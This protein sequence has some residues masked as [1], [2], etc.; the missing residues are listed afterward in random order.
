MEAIVLEKVD[1]IK[2]AFVVAQAI[3]TSRL[4]PKVLDILINTKATVSIAC[5]GG[6]DSLSL[7]LLLFGHFSKTGRRLYV[8]H[9][10]HKLRNAESDAEEAFVREVCRQLDL[11]IIAHHDENPD[12]GASESVLRKKRHDFF[13]TCLKQ[14]NSN[15]LCFGH[16]RED[17]AETLLMRI[18]RG[19]GL[20]GLCGPRPV[21]DFKE[22]NITYLR[23]LIEIS[24][25][26][27]MSALE[28]AGVAWCED[29]SNVL[30]HYF[31]NRVRH[32][33][34][35]EWEAAA[36]WSI[37]GG[38]SKTRELLEED[39]DALEY[40]VQSLFPNLSAKTHIL[41]LKPLHNKPK[42]LYRRVIW[43]W[44]LS[45]NLVDSFNAHSFEILLTALM[46]Q[47]FAK[48]SVGN[49]HFLSFENNQ[50]LLEK[51]SE[52]P[53]W[54]IISITPGSRLFFP[55]GSSLKMD[56]VKLND[57]L[58]SSILSGKID[59]SREAYLSLQEETFLFIK[60]WKTG[61]RYKP[62][63][64]P[65]SKKLQDVFT[66]RKI[67]S[68]LRQ[69][70]PIIINSDEKILWIPGL[71]IAEEFKI[72]KGSEVAIKLTFC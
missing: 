7:L 11:E 65:G 15:I 58:K 67:D 27:L 55:N 16:Q 60:Q 51:F 40:W 43:K 61:D 20:G 34:V 59:N 31:R 29:S 14:I 53:T 21:M 25:Q 24:K 57:L 2:A 50:L 48:L 5:S 4:H 33:V 71:P 28:S 54:G 72:L 1:W 9:Y 6:A 56:I 47:T 12:C 69:T 13:N 32:N 63:G 44:F 62:L 26:E 36:P 41:D 52:K 66:D 30:D 17:V 46:H 18:A 42:S 68:K 37:W 38:L 19:S 35:P 3:P 39:D 64:A 49:A 8:F 70:L 22:N 10:N 45:H 23:P